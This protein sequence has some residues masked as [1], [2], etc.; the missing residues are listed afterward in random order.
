M[1]EIQGSGKHNNT[2]HDYL[3]DDFNSEIQKD[4]VAFKVS[5]PE[6]SSVSKKT[7]EGQESLQKVSSNNHKAV[8]ISSST[9]QQQHIE[10]RSINGITEIKDNTDFSFFNDSLDPPI[11]VKSANKDKLEEK[12]NAA[13]YRYELPNNYYN[14]EQKLGHMNTSRKKVR[15]SDPLSSS[16]NK[17]HIKTH[18]SSSSSFQRNGYEKQRS[19]GRKRENNNFDTLDESDDE[20]FRSFA[21]QSKVK[22]P[23]DPFVKEIKPHGANIS[24]RGTDRTNPNFIRY[25]EPEKKQDREDDFFLEDPFENDDPFKNDDPFEEKKEVKSKGRT[26]RHNSYKPHSS[27]KSKHSSFSDDDDEDDEYESKYNSKHHNHH[28]KKHNVTHSR[29]QY[30]ND[31]SSDSDDEGYDYDDEGYDSEEEVEKRRRRRWGHLR[32]MTPGQKKESLLNEVRQLQEDGVMIEGIFDM[33]TNDDKIMDSIEA[34]EIRAAEDDGVRIASYVLVGIF[35]FIETT[36]YNT[37]EYLKIHGIT[38]EAFTNRHKFNMYLRRIYRMYLSGGGPE[39]PFWG[40]LVAMGGMIFETHC[41]NL[42]AEFMT[43]QLNQAGGNGNPMGNLMKNMM[44]NLQD[45]TQNAPNNQSGNN[46]G[47]PIDMG[48]IGGLMNNIFASFK[49][50]QNPNNDPV[51]AN[52]IY[53]QENGGSATTN[54]EMFT[55]SRN[56]SGRLPDPPDYNPRAF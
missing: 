2:S 48:Q 28:N 41:M 8:P 32:K 42:G 19:G 39:N 17:N 15:F 25:V 26:S 5:D 44:G 50:Q 47:G 38:K 9:N 16:S 31:E 53:G 34:A 56:R 52:D 4:V 7:E 6:P 36:N 43:N 22:K 21:N 1:N 33:N 55:N 13:S 10:T 23:I 20:W 11:S 40:L 24:G 29:H 3:I 35:Y 46:N 45:L 37:G 51:T 49:Q 18:H 54:P 27:T 30:N 14:N 12:I